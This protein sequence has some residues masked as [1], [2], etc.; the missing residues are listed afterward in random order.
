M[1]TRL[2]L[3]AERRQRAGQFHPLV[4][5]ECCR[6]VMFWVRMVEDGDGPSSRQCITGSHRCC[7][8]REV[9]EADSDLIVF[10]PA[11]CN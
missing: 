1:R 9:G 3:M 5:A 4:N 10:F 8:P 7:I 6:S 2:V 11:L